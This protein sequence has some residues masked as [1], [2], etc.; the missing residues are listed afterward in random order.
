[1][2][3]AVI[4]ARMAS[5]RLP[6]K[7]LRPLAGRPVLGWVVRAA[8]QADG[9]DEVVVA[10]TTAADDGDV[11]EYA[12]ELGA[13]VFRGSE[14]DVLGRFV[15]AT[16]GRTG[17]VVRLTSDCPLLDPAIIAMTLATFEAGDEEYVSTISPRSLPRGLDVEVVSRE[18]LL[19]ADAQATGADRAHVTSW[20][21]R[22]PGRVRIA[23]LTFQPAADDL[24]VTLDTEADGRALDAIVAELG[25]RPPAWRELVALLRDRPDIVALNAEVHQKTLDEG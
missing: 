14:Q 24:R 16:E 18:A 5:T 22:E 6:G 7:V 17:A 10:T 2:A 23:G 11:A 13:E 12:A 21:Y 3:V 9:I 25:D 4:Q 1:M 8:R 19:R 15:N 20:L